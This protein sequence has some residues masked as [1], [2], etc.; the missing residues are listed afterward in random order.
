VTE[1]RRKLL[2]FAADE[3]WTQEPLVGM[4]REI[5]NGWLV[6]ASPGLL[7]QIDARHL[8]RMLS[9][10]VERAADVSGREHGRVEDFLRRLQHE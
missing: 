6:L 1:I 8:R 4:R 9:Q 10:A 3:V 5:W 7:D 2:A